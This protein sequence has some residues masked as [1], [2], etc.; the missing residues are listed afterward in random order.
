MENLVLQIRSYEQIFCRVKTITECAKDRYDYWNQ[1]D[2]P[3]KFLYEIVL[4][5]VEQ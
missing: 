5:T 3:Y 1:K 2:E 4:L